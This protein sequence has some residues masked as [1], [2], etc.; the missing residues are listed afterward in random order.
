MAMSCHGYRNGAPPG[1][2]ESMIPGHKDAAQQLIDPISAPPP[3]KVH[4]SKN[5][6]YA[7]AKLSVSII[8]T[9][10]MK[11]KGFLLQARKIDESSEKPIGYFAPEASKGTKVVCQ[12]NT[13]NA[14]THTSGSPGSSEEKSNLT[15]LWTSTS[16]QGHIQFRATIVV[17]YNTFWVAERSIYIQDK[18]S[19]PLPFSTRA[20]ASL[21]VLLDPID[22]NACGESKGC[23]RNPPGC[24]QQTCDL[25][26]TWT[27][28]RRTVKFE[29]S[30]DADGWIAM[31]F[32][33][34]K[35]MGN[36]DVVECVWNEGL[37]EVMVQNS[38][39]RENA[40]SNIMLQDRTLGLLRTVGHLSAGRISCKFEREIAMTTGTG[41]ADLTDRFH[42]FLAKG[43]VTPSG[44]K[45]RHALEPGKY[46]WITPYKVSVIDKDDVTNTAKYALVKIHGCLMIIAWM[47]CATTAIL[48]VK[49]YKPMWPN[50]KLCG[51]RVWFAVHR[52]CLLTTLVCTVL[53][54][55]LI[56]IH[57][58]A[59]S[60]MPELP[61][62]A[63][64]PLGIT[65]TILCILNPLLAMCRPNPESKW[66]PVFN[67]IHWFFGLVAMV[68]ATPTLFIGLN[69]HKAFVPWWA[70]WVLVA[71]MLFHLIIELLLEIHGCLNSRKQES[72]SEEF[73][74]RKK[75][76]PRGEYYGLN[77]EPVGTRFKKTILSIYLFVAIVLTIVMV[78]TIAAG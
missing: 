19:G 31:A 70:T 1:A 46:P 59:Y 78:I 48:M 17:D 33:K 40:K 62:K 4:V 61:D 76:D 64:P 30:G 71:F 13:G 26:L 58:R 60:T 23:Y 18:D 42:I 9:G 38:Y 6:T 50:D 35:N 22:T 45:L 65:V 29:L 34:D 11:F 69:L 8:A 41:L 3:F 14:L 55:I 24:N 66:R 73:E 57:R 44:E 68:L 16:S 56:F 5:V 28:M 53:G 51:E 43:D 54:F 52:G 63:H 74:L 36:D 75:S 32:S 37:S 72:R 77:P 67:W 2:C 12:S 10:D 20:P 27:P 47:L 21:P 25:I 7:G 39:N 15:V 49:Y